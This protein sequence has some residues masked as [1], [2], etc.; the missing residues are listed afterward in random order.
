MSVHSLLESVLLYKLFHLLKL[1]LVDSEATPRQLQQ[2]ITTTSTYHFLLQ[3]H[4]HNNHRHPVI[5]LSHSWKN[6]MSTSPIHIHHPNMANRKF[7][8]IYFTMVVRRSSW[9]ATSSAHLRSLFERGSGTISSHMS[10]L[11]HIRLKG[12]DEVVC[13]TI[14]L[15]K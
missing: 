11:A 12:G 15:N 14:A 5:N 4:H 13:A 6:H 8:S 1:F 9:W 2:N 3:S 10:W 7:H